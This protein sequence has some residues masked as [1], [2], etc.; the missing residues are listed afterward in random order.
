M[1]L[2]PTPTTT[3]VPDEA[4]PVVDAAALEFVARLEQ[5]HGPRRRELLRRRSERQDRFDAG[6]R[7]DFLE[8]TSV[9]RRDDWTVSPVPEDLRDRRCEI[10]GPTDRKMVVNALNSGARVFMADFEDANSPTWANMTLGQ[11]NLHDAIRRDIDFTG[12]NGKR[13]ELVDEPATL[14]VRPRGLHL[15]ERNMLVD[16]VPVSASLFDFGVYMYANAQELTERGSGPYFYLAKLE[17]HLDAR[18]WNDVFL[19][20]QEMLGLERGT[21][22]ATV[23]IETLPAAFQMHEILFELREH[24]AGL[25]AGRWDYIFSVIKTHRNQP[26]LVLPD[27]T[28]IDMTVPFMRAYTELLVQTCHRRGAHAMGGMA[29][30]IP[31]R[32]DEDVNRLALKKVR[33]D[34]RR[35]AMDGCDGTWV[36]HP[37]LVPVATE[38]FDEVLG[39]RPNQIDRRRPDVE[40]DATDL[41]DL[42]VPGGSITEAGVKLNVDVAIR[43]LASWLTG[44]GAAAINDLMEDTATAE[45]SRS[46]VWQWARARAITVEGTVITPEYVRSLMYAEAHLLRREY[47]DEAYEAGRFGEACR[48]FERV[49]LDDEFHHFLTI[50]AYDMLDITDGS[51]R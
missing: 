10:T 37:D 15:E 1:M 23:L 4:R 44:T 40:V 3:S 48:L 36:A 12:E 25:N 38:V 19:T 33:E 2:A 30:F 5:R 34:K 35:E 16:G 21:I 43:Y 7:Y 24:S 14:V 45:I 6:E 8:H 11:R 32:R 13:Y 50:P 17:S 42:R 26:D 31:S 18:W 46:Q 9:I 28:D 39:H 20:A 22:K 47:G 41:L 51:R 49:A 29:A 27:R